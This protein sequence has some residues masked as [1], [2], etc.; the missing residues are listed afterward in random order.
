M[1]QDERL[2]C[3]G[4][5]WGFFSGSGTYQ[6]AEAEHS[7]ERLASLGLDWICIPVNC[8]QETFYSLNIFSM[9]GRTQTDEDVIFAVRKAKSLGLKVCLKPMVDCLDRS[10]RARIDFPRENPMY[11]E[12][13]FASYTRFMLHYAALAERLG[14]EMLCTGREMAGMDKNSKHC[15]QVIE[16][17]RGVYSGLIMHNINHGDELRFDWLGAVDVIGISAYYPVTVP[18]DRS[19]EMMRKSWQYHFERVRKCHEKYGLPVMFAEIGV[20]NEQGCTGY[21]WDFRNRPELPAD[22]R[23]QADFYRT[24]MEISWEEPWFAGYFW[25]DWKA[26]LPP[27]DKAHENRDFTVYGK[28]AEQVLREFYT[29]K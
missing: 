8:F 27:E 11:L 17:V 3:K 10:W 7:M 29:K 12:R 23:E 26:K 28:Q 4:Y 22:E 1:Q 18:Q 15:R 5:T 24:A 21:P 20:R 6:T 13:W 16:E 9:F 2:F 14:C 25:W 19:I